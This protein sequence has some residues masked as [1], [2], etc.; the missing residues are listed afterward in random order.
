M[1]LTV[2]IGNSRIKLALF[3]DRKLTNE[4]AFS[5]WN[6]VEKLDFDR[7]IFSSTAELDLPEFLNQSVQLSDVNSYPIK[8]D[9]QTFETLGQDR[10]AN[11]CATVGLKE[12]A[13]LII[14]VGTCVT[15]DLVAD[16]VF[17]GGAISPGC[18][19]RFKAMNNFTANLPLTQLDDQVTFPGKST[20]ANLRVGVFEGLI[21]ELKQFIAL[22]EDNFPEL[23]VIL[24]GGNYAPFA[25]ALK[26]STFADPNLTLRGL[27]EILL[28]LSN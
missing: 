25:K 11:A 5:S 28:H 4:L 27:N 9:Y 21:G 10:I 23:K 13:H 8:F 24:T 7:S 19:M 2:D 1:N 22:S 12:T 6:E 18:E 15:Y 16:S 3:E 20:N 17:L 26:S 14:D